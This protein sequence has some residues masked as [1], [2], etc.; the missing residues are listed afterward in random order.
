M[1]FLIDS[2]INSFQLG[3]LNLTGKVSDT[4]LIWS[5]SLFHLVRPMNYVFVISMAKTKTDDIK[6]SFAKSKIIN[7]T[8]LI[9][10]QISIFSNT[11]AL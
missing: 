8:T 10:L 7:N 1:A 9:S 4:S 3:E 11:L 2:S 5:I 6:S